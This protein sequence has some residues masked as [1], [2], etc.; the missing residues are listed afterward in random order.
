MLKVVGLGRSGVELPTFCTG[1]FSSIDKATASGR[2]TTKYANRTPVTHRVT[3]RPTHVQ[4]NT[5]STNHNMGV[6]LSE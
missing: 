6:G 3:L 2:Q 5:P 4:Y 1:W